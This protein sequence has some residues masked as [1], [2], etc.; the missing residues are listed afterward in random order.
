MKRVVG[1]FAAI[2]VVFAASVVPASAQNVS[3]GYQYQ[4]LSGAVDG[5]NMPTG[6]NVDVGVPIAP[7]VAIVGQYDYSRKSESEIIAGTSVDAAINVSTFGGGIRWTGRTP[8]IAPFIDVLFGATHFSGGAHVAGIEAASGSETDAM[9]Q[10]GGGIAVPLTPTVSAIGQ[11][12]Y[13]RMFTE[14]EGTNSIRFVA[15]IRVGFGH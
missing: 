10:L 13:R 15:G 2:G 6:F 7:G 1:V 4:H 3:F 12:D 9:L 14:D 11:F 8:S 5:L